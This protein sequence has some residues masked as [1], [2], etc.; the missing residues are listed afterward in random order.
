MNIPASENNTAIKFC[1]A[2]VFSS[3]LTA[4]SLKSKPHAKSGFTRN[5]FSGQTF[6]LW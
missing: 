5:N 4:H 3:T 1:A 6:D 2:Y